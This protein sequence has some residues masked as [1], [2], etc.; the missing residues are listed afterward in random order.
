MNIIKFP[1][2]SGCGME[3]FSQLMLKAF[4]SVENNLS[5]SF[6]LDATNQNNLSGMFPNVSFFTWEPRNEYLCYGH[7][8]E[9]AMNGKNVKFWTGLDISPQ[10][11]SFIIWF[12]TKNL[13]QGSTITQI[14][15]LPC[16]RNEKI[17]KGN[18]KTCN[19][20][21]VALNNDDFQ[22]FCDNPHVSSSLEDFIIAVFNLI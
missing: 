20:L 13:S 8:M 15:N 14:L 7:Y 1:F 9:Y 12:D 21:W 5:C 16:P 18:S 17:E 22:Q 3:Y 4:K 2:N 19:S 10:N 6:I 11:I